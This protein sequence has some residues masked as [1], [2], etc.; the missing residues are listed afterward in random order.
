MKKKYKMLVRNGRIHI[1]HWSGAGK[2]FGPEWESIAMFDDK[3][4][5]LER[6]RKIIKNMNECDMH[7][8]RQ[9]DD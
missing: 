4:C 5:N 9:E 2:I 8:N 1:L 6:C 7:T 3:D